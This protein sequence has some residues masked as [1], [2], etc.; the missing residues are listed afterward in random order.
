MTIERIGDLTSKQITHMDTACDYILMAD[1][2]IAEGDEE[3]AARLINFAELHENAAGMTIV[4]TGPEDN[5]F[6]Y[7]YEERRMDRTRLIRDE[8]GMRLV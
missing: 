3:R 7:L 6:E 1:A 4:E 5:P 2:A 8:M